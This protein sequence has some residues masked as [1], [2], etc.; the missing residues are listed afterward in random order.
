M[1]DIRFS[2]INFK[3]SKT[4]DWKSK[5][6]ALELKVLD[7]DALISQLQN[8]D[9]A[10]EDKLGNLNKL[11]AQKIRALMKSIQDLKKD[12]AE[13]KRLNKDH[14][15]SE[16]IENLKKEIMEQD[17]IIKCVRKVA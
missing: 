14:K 11:H 17:I 5:A 8:E 10:D 1:L 13:A 6:R 12:L 9:K 16:M 7:Q 4:V 2:Y 15:R 3:M